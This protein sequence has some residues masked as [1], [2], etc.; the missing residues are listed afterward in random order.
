MQ[1]TVEV[2]WGDW[3]LRLVAIWLLRLAATD[4]DPVLEGETTMLFVVFLNFVDRGTQWG[5]DNIGYGMLDGTNE[6]H[7]P[8]L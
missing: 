4:L 7:F 5:Q 8:L 6:L 3:L 2:G 1:T